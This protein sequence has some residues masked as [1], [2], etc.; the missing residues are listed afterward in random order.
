MT[1]GANIAA[2]IWEFN[3]FPLRFSHKDNLQ[4]PECQQNVRRKACVHAAISLTLDGIY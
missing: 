4:R 2:Y 1:P 3:N